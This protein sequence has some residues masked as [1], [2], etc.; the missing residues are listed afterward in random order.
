MNVYIFSYTYFALNTRSHTHYSLFWRGERRTRNSCFIREKIVIVCYG[1]LSY[2][3]R[4]YFENKIHCIPVNIW[5]YVKI[6]MIHST[7]ITQKLYSY[8]LAVQSK[9][10]NTKLTSEFS[11]SDLFCISLLVWH[12]VINLLESIL[13]LI[14]L[15]VF[16]SQCMFLLLCFVDYIL[17]LFWKVPLSLHHK[18]KNSIKIL[19]KHTRFVAQKNQP[20]TAS[21]V[22]S[23]VLKEQKW[24]L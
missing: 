2:A 23:N 17:K 19:A 5:I 12:K 9:T 16:L 4:K 8:L 10:R 15:K 7:S 18:I 1:I 24:Q 6:L 11:K 20:N 3:I 21:T 22:Q 13:F 14:N